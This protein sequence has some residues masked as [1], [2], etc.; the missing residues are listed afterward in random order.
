[1]PGAAHARNLLETLVCALE[2]E[3]WFGRSEQTAASAA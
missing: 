3:G 2:Q 1:M